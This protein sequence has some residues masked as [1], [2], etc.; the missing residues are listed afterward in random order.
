MKAEEVFA[1]VDRHF[2][3]ET[4]ELIDRVCETF[5]DTILWEAPA[6]NLV[7]TEHDKI[8]DHYRKIVAGI[9]PPIKEEK[10]RRFA[11]GNEAFDDRI[12]Y[13]TAGKDNV[14][15]VPAGKKVKLRLVHYFQIQGDKICHEVG[16]E[17]WQ[18]VS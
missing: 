7:F 18:I 2:N 8:A 3:F 17:M 14:W 16:Y 6:R 12:I 10:I 4:P 15:G 11:S 13:F 1:V 9:L 5:A